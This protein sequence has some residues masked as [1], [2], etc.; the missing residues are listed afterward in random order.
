[1]PYSPDEKQILRLADVMKDLRLTEGWKEYVK[2]LDTQIK[3][4]EQVVQTP[5]SASIVAFQG[6]D[7]NTRAVHVEAVKGALIAL[8]LARDLPNTIIDHANEIRAKNS[9]GDDNG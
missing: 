6:M 9:P 4:R 1:M 5:L 7:F 2:V 8:R 3:D